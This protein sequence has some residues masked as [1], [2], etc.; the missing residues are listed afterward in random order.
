MNKLLT[1]FFYV[2]WNTF[3]RRRIFRTC[4]CLERALYYSAIYR[5][6][7]S[8]QGTLEAETDE[9]RSKDLKMQVT[10]NKEIISIEMSTTNLDLARDRQIRRKTWKHYNRWNEQGS[11]LRLDAAP[12]A[13]PRKSRHLTTEYPHLQKN[14]CFRDS[15]FHAGLNR[16]RS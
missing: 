1:K 7:E 4:L 16:L 14:R 6:K 5:N 15:D 12:V 9:A 10:A 2:R 8:S 11:N 3:C 13:L